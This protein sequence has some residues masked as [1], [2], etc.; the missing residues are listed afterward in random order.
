M[1]EN[2]FDR[3]FNMDFLSYIGP[4]HSTMADV[5]KHQRNILTTQGPVTNME[6]V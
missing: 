2:L 4:T 6:Q 1:V 3:D 5:T